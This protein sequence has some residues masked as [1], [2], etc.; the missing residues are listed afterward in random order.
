MRKIVLFMY[1][2]MEFIS[3]LLLTILLM[4][5]INVTSNKCTAVD[6]FYQCDNIEQLTQVKNQLLNVILDKATT[7]STNCSKK[8]SDNNLSNED[9]AKLLESEL[10]E[11]VNLKKERINIEQIYNSCYK[12]ITDNNNFKKVVNYVN[13]LLANKEYISSEISKTNI[14]HF[15]EIIQWWNYN[16]MRYVLEIYRQILEHQIKQKQSMEKSTTDKLVEN[17][18]I[19]FLQEVLHPY[20][21]NMH[22]NVREYDKDKIHVL[23]LF[24]LHCYT[25]L[26]IDNNNYLERFSE[27]DLKELNDN[28][29]LKN[30]LINYKYDEYYE[31][32]IKNKLRNIYSI[33]TIID[34]FDIDYCNSMTQ[35]E[36]AKLKE[37]KQENITTD[38][39][40]TMIRQIKDYHLLE[41]FNTLIKVILNIQEKGMLNKI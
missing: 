1:K 30:M 5:S 37:F 39:W 24:V 9:K 36:Q 6:Q 35:E 29:E 13:D 22:T 8:Y 21:Y 23:L 31:K 38:D 32:I 27:C 40:N 25:M 4:F 41:S 19:D 17:K 20:N 34:N 3:K 14:N 10:E 11:L 16:K 28:K 15:L 2:L 18:V 33:K 7:I 12:T 26:K